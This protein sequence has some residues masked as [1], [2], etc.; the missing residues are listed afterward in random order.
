MTASGGVAGT[1]GD[2]PR[3]TAVPAVVDHWGVVLGLGIVTVGLG[4]VLTFRPDATLRFLAVV[5]AIEFLLSGLV[6]IASA[7]SPGPKDGTLRVLAA[8]SGIIGVLVGLVCLR[9]P[10]QT[11]AVIGLVL[12]LWWVLRGLVE[13]VR[14]LMPGSV[15]PDPRAWL[16]FSGV[17]TAGAGLVVLLDP[18]TS[19]KFLLVLVAVWLYVKGGIAIV[20]ALGMRSAGR[21]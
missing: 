4:V 5:V 21:A 11:L 12:G 2:Q 7:V 6:S 14:A 17:V 1:T 8:L 15:S 18:E 13:V 20:A 16:L 9:A 10:Q 19:L 3:G